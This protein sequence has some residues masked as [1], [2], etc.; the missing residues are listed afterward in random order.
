MTDAGKPLQGSAMMADYCRE[1]RT[2]RSAAIR[3]LMP[4]KAQART[5][6]DRSTSGASGHPT[7]KLDSHI[8]TT[9]LLAV[10]LTL[11]PLRKWQGGGRGSAALPVSGA[12]RAH[13]CP[14]I[15]VP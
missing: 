1:K 12:Q 11:E 5:I 8:Q 7:W 14:G 4:R 3:A 9:D 13:W 15:F 2:C 6:D 10:L